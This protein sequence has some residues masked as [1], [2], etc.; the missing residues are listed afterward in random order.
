[1]CKYLC[2]LKIDLT[3]FA[4]VSAA[5]LLGARPNMALD[6]R[7]SHTG[8]PIRIRGQQHRGSVSHQL[9]GAG[10]DQRRGTVNILFSWYRH[11]I[12]KSDR[13]NLS[14]Q[15]HVIYHFNP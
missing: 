12:I 5:E 6:R 13:L 9:P 14:E 3:L 1:M 4:Y 2:G 11:H 7:K 15:R 10:N 8:V